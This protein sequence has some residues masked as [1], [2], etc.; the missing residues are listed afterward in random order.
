MKKAIFGVIILILVAALIYTADLPGVIA[1]K[2]IDDVESTTLRITFSG[3]V[4]IVEAEGQTWIDWLKL[5]TPNYPMENQWQELKSFEVTEPHAMTNDGFGNTL[6]N[7]NFG[8]PDI[9]SNDYQIQMVVK[10]QRRKLSPKSGS[11]SGNS[12]FTQ[13]TQYIESNDP[14]IIALANEITEGSDGKYDEFIKITEWVHD[15]VEYSN[16]LQATTE[17]AVWTNQHRIG[18]CDEYS[19]LEIALLRARGIPARYVHG[20]APSSDEFTGWQRH[21]WVEAWFGTWIPV[22]PT[23][24]EIDYIDAAHLKLVVAPDQS[25]VN[26][27]ATVSGGGIGLEPLG[28]PDLN[29]TVLEVVKR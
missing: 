11:Y 12:L 25:F 2:P 3:N 8:S 9:G 23:W 7:I 15:N 19:H 16:E 20:I 4:K 24:G 14:E 28:V 27:E 18:A 22:D 29:V 26:K 17:S 21:S 1:P 13:P 10:L 6:L 5:K